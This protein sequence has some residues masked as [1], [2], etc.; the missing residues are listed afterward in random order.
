[1]L[2]FLLRKSQYFIGVIVI[3]TLICALTLYVMTT[4]SAVCEIYNAFI[5][6]DFS[7][8]STKILAV[9]FLKITDLFIICLGL[10]IIAVGIYKLYINEK[11]SLPKE[12]DTKSLADLKASLVKIATLVLLILFVEQAVSLG[13]SENLL[14]FGIAIAAVIASV[15]WSK[16][17]FL[18]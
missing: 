15:A 5:G 7:V 12:I 1:M 6:T 4:L 8:N 14:G 17:Q 16:N 10:Q 2:E 9:K 13:P 11:V 18:K 3:V